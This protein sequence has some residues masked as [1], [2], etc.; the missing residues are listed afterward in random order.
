MP[1]KSYTA[2]FNPK[3]I[4]GLNTAAD[5][6]TL[7]GEIGE[8]CGRAMN[9]ITNDAPYT[10]EYLLSQITTASDT[11]TNFPCCHGDTAGRWIWAQA[12]AASAE[13]APPA[14]VT[15]LVGKAIALQ[16]TDGHYGNP[17][18]EAGV[19]T[20]LGAYGNGWMAK[21][22]PV[23]TEFFGE[24]AD[25]KAVENHVQWYLDQY[26]YWEEV[27]KKVGERDTE[28]YAVTP[29][30]YFHGL[31]GLMSAYRLTKDERIVVLAKKFMRH[32]VPL[33]EADHSHSYLTVR[34]GAL[35][36]AAVTGDTELLEMIASD[37]E[38]VWK[39]F[40][41]EN[42]GIPERFVE[43]TPGEIYDD[44]ACSHADW[45]LLCFKLHNMTGNSTWFDRGILCM[46]NQFFYNQLVNGG[47]GSR[48]VQ[49]NKYL[50]MGKEASW[51]CSLYGPSLIL[52][53]SSYF[54]QLEGDTLTIH[55]PIDATVQFGDQTVELS[56]NGALENYAVDL[57]AAPGIKAVNLHQP[58][59]VEWEK[60]KDGRRTVFSAHWKLWN[61]AA[62]KAPEAITPKSGETCT[63]FIGPWMLAARPAKN[64]DIPTLS[65][66][67]ATVKTIKGLPESPKALRVAVP[68]DI[69]LNQYDVFKWPGQP[70][71]EI[72]LYPLK[73]KES[74]DNAK[75]WFKCSQE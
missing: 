17:T 2:E 35:E 1:V 5:K 9:R 26:A 7:K 64:V 22:M 32:L 40:V 75:T 23:Y 46:E 3:K 72:L 12:L 66:K 4:L 29:S 50:Q 60:C 70:D 11:W 8:R 18:I 63:Q 30:G 49:D 45:M 54:V 62:G 53:G 24:T 34:R 10:E 13:D 31:D 58:F 41:M 33:S 56:W 57:S 21:G 59:W 6:I 27:T 38:E 52:E 15:E 43:F 48:M 74:P 42:G 36:L 28:Y 73:D 47:F 25:R 44:E 37:L 61:G 14:Y 19:E 16:Q 65:I 20:M 51:C 68:S 69:E 67:D 55:H 39:L 71:N